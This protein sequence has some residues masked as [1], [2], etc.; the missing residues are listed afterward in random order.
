MP[1]C[2]RQV[3]PPA[4]RPERAS[5][6]QGCAPW[7]AGEPG[8][9]GWAPSPPVAHRGLPCR[10]GRAPAS[11]GNRAVRASWRP[12]GTACPGGACATGSLSGSELCC[13]IATRTASP[14]DAAGRNLGDELAQQAPGHRREPMTTYTVTCV[15]VRAGR[16]GREVDRVHAEDVAGSISISL[17]AFAQ[18]RTGYPTRRRSDPLSA[19]EGVSQAMAASGSRRCFT[20]TCGDDP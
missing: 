4:L 11:E 18:F 13:G 6:G 20:Q 9:P 1:A 10:T 7:T 3:G 16:S 15:F 17:I 14:A 19:G 12:T 8:S 2:L 5:G